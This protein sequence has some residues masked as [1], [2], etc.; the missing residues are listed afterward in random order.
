V[1]LYPASGEL[2]QVDMLA[3][4]LQKAGFLAGRGA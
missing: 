1:V 3:E 4:A 2:E